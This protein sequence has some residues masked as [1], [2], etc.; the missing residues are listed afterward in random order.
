MTDPPMDIRLR[1]LNALGLTVADRD[2]RVT[3]LTP[4]G[5]SPAMVDSAGLWIATL[6]PALTL[7]TT[8][9]VEI[10]NPRYFPYTTSFT[11]VNNSH[12]GVPDFTCGGPG[13]AHLV[14]VTPALTDG[15]AVVS[16]LLQVDTR[17]DPLRIARPEGPN[18]FHKQLAD[19]GS[20]HKGDE[21]PLSKLKRPLVN[22]SSSKGVERLVYDMQT[23]VRPDGRV[24]VFEY[25]TTTAP[26]LL[27]VW[28]ADKMS[29]S[30][31]KPATPQFKIPYH[32]YFHPTAHAGAAYPY[33]K[34]AGGGQPHVGVGYRHLMFE[35]WGSVQHYYSAKRVVYVVPVGSPQHQFG[36]AGHSLGIWTL[37]CETNLALHQVNGASYGD[38]QAQSVGQVAVSGFS[39]GANFM[40]HAL[41]D[42][43]SPLGRSFV[44]NHLKELY[45]W[46]GAIGG[47][48]VANTVPQSFGGFV[49]TWWRDPSQQFRVYT[50]NPAY[51]KALSFLSSY[52]RP[53]TSGPAGAFAKTW[54]RDGKDFGT[55]VCLP[56]SFFRAKGSYAAHEDPLRVYRGH[57]IHP[58]DPGFPSYIDTHHWF[59]TVSMYHALNNAQFPSFPP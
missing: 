44:Q 28:H 25:K 53:A 2:Q 32:F 18:W 59:P 31:P 24:Y 8:L 54:A 27:F 40:L 48:G 58:S 7:P 38:Y 45:S 10:D 11:V 51:D 1:I 29:F 19:E 33:G 36:E 26:K 37:L 55:L 20:F 17:P 16:K 39:A 50:Q 52:E 42:R 6:P 41:S 13:L 56:N 47:K 30:K 9:H 22:G 12:T 34:D 35:T 15:I 4:A 3:V 49:R 14:A 57:D 21:K 5:E 46:D 43:S 23:P